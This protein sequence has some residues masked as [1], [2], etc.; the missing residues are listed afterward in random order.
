MTKTIFDNTVWSLNSKIV[1]N[2][3]K[4]GSI[5]NELKKLIKALDLDLSY[6]I[7]KSHFEEDGTQNYLLFQPI[8]RYFKIMT[9]TKYI[10]SWKSKGLS[11]ET[12]KPYAT[13]DNGLMP[14]IDYYGSKVRVKFNKGRLKQ[15]KKLAYDYG[16][17]VNIYFV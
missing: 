1:E 9:N 4:N 2:K 14:L 11:N 10:S 3:T 7:G 12:I 6:L 15:L 17:R 13:S 16:S 5:E 8:K